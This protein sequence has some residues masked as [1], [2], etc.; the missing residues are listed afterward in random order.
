M[1]QELTIS[2]YKSIGENTRIHFGESIS[3]FIGL[4]GSGKSNILDTLS[5]VKDSLLLGLSAAITHRGGING[6]RRRSLGRPYDLKIGIGIKLP[7]IKSA[8]YEFILEGDQAEEYKVKREYAFI[9]LEDGSLTVFERKKLNIIK[10]ANGIN[11]HLRDDSLAITL[12]SGDQRFKPLFDFMS[13]MTIYSIFPDTIRKPQKFDPTRPMKMH[14]ENWA[15][16]L[17][18]LIRDPDQK[19]QLIDALYRLTGD[20]KDVRLAKM[21]GYLVAQFKQSNK[22]YANSKKKQWFD[23]EQQSDGTLRVAGLLTALLQTDQMSIIGIEEPELTVHPGALQMLYDYIRQS[24]ELHQIIIT[25]HSPTILDVVDINNDHLFVVHRKDGITYI[26]EANPAD[27]MPVKESLYTLSDFALNSNILQL[28]LF[29]E[30][31]T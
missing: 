24:S 7:E 12:L 22:K 9:E 23:A 16:V 8:Y 17:Q 1:I 2:N 11:L 5:F 6:V 15:S 28:T 27:L 19:N 10:G 14:G 25:T 31:E 18:E 3:V 4:N 29:D 26:K 20:V 21:A 13:T 30:S